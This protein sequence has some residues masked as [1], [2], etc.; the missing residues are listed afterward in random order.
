MLA[1]SDRLDIHRF[2]VTDL[3]FTGS[4]W[5]LKGNVIVTTF[6]RFILY[7][8]N[9]KWIKVI[10]MIIIIIISYNNNYY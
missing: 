2:S 8:Y 3:T 1:F 4:Q 9:I 6:K 7:Y 5:D 10:I